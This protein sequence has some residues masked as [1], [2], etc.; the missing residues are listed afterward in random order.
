MNGLELGKI[1]REGYRSERTAEYLEVVGKEEEVVQS[2]ESQR[3]NW[4]RRNDL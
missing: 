4:E 1:Q 3:N 2:R